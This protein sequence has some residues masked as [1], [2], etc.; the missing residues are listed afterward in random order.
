MLL[1]VKDI[2]RLF[3]V[4]PMIRRLVI[5]NAKFGVCVQTVITIIWIALFKATT[6]GRNSRLFQ[7]G[8]QCLLLFG[9]SIKVS[10]RGFALDL[11]EFHLHL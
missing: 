9:A 1:V 10:V 8:F 2:D 7:F 6:S 4:H 11:S 5:R 3:A